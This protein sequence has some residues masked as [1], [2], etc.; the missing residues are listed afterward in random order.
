MQEE[1]KKSVLLLTVFLTTIYWI[2]SNT[3]KK[4]DVSYLT[5]PP[6]NWQFGPC[7]PSKHWHVPFT[8]IP[9]THWLSLHLLLHITWTTHENTINKL[10]IPRFETY[11]RRYFDLNRNKNICMSGAILNHSWETQLRRLSLL[12][13]WTK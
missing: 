9:F 8:H 2:K 1:V 3:I 13:F 4:L 10:K 12:G 11:F 5:F 6:Q 7:H